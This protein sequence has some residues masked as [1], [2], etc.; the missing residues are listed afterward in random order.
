MTKSLH[1]HYKSQGKERRKRCV[2]RRLQ[3]TGRDG[4]DVTWRGRSFQVRK[5]R[6]GKLDRQRSTAVYDG[7]TAM[8]STVDAE[9]RRVLVSKRVRRLEKFVGQVRRCRSVET[10]QTGSTGRVCQNSKLILNSLW[11]LQPVQCVRGQRVEFVD[12]QQSRL[13]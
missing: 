2:F 7:Q 5:R 12:F 6:P 4:A 11:S 10:V 13:C 9:R 1:R 8:T 3:K